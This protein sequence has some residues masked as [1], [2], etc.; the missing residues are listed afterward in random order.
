MRGS[1]HVLSFAGLEG[2]ATS[3]M[4][5]AEGEPL[6]EGLLM[7]TESHVAAIVHELAIEPRLLD[8]VSVLCSQGTRCTRLEHEHLSG[9]DM[10]MHRSCVWLGDVCQDHNMC[11][12]VVAQQQKCGLW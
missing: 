7:A 5:I 11:R 12:P 3:T 9:G 8:A 2:V 4:E 10:R 1:P 6:N